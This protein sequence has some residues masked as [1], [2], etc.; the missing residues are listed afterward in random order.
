M[1]N[2]E[3]LLRSDWTVFRGGA[4]FFNGA[5]NCRIVDCEFDQ[6]GGNAVFVNKYN[7]ITIKGCYIHHAG[8]NGVSFV[9]DPSTVRSQYSDMATRTSKRWIEHLVL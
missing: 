9:G 2:K 7:H 3:P 5:K 8:A 6:V 1:E 4:I